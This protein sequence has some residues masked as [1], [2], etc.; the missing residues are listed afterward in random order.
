[1]GGVFFMAKRV[2]KVGQSIQWEDMLVMFLA[3]KKAQ[4]RSDI[5]IKDYN[6]HVRQFYRRY[7]EGELQANLYAYMSGKIAPATHNIRLAYLK[8]YYKVKK[9]YAV[10]SLPE[11]L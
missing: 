7:P 2:R 1:M 4:G 9:I 5:T 3:E 6:Y 11:P 10:K 8:A